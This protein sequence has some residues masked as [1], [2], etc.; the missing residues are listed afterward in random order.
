ME[1]DT[2]QASSESEP[3]QGTLELMRLRMA[4][5]R[6]FQTVEEWWAAIEAEEVEAT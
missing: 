1:R 2:N 3:R 5:R 6:G 4:Q